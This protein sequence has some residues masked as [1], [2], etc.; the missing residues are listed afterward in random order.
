MDEGAASAPGAIVSQTQ[1]PANPWT[2]RAE[3]MRKALVMAGDG[4][5][6]PRL[7]KNWRKMAQLPA[8]AG[9]EWLVPEEVE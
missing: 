1:I 4:A 8:T 3:F 6:E 7:M 9:V 5:L 2:S